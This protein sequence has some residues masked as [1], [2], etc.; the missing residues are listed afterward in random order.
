MDETTAAGTDETVARFE[1]LTASDLAE[2]VLGLAAVGVETAGRVVE[3]I[4]PPTLVTAVVTAPLRAAVT[5]LGSRLR[6]GGWSQEL[7]RRGDSRRGGVGRR[8]E[9]TAQR[10]A[11]ARLGAGLGWGGPTA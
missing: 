8:V 6:R 5:G 7:L 9:G 10:G 3:R 2:L 4:R 1:P 11:A